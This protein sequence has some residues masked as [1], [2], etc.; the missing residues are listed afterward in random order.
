M[1]PIPAT[2]S[3]RRALGS[4]TLQSHPEAAWRALVLVRFMVGAVFVSEGLQKFLYP[5]DVGAGRFD[6]IGFDHPELVAGLVGV[7]E[8]ACGAPVLIGLLTRPAAAVLAAVM[9]GALVTTKLPILLGHD[10]G[11][12][13]VRTLDRYG[14]WAMAHE[15]RTDWAMILGALV[16]VWAGSGPRAVDGALRRRGRLVR[17]GPIDARAQGAG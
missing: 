4:F 15:M 2:S 6:Q 16:L 9:T 14:F 13:A 10:L 11:P 5:A 8:V 17:P 3:E 7:A 1:D 12:F